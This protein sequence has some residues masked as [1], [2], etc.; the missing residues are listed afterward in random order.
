MIPG[1]LIPVRLATDATLAVFLEGSLLLGATWLLSALLRRHSPSVRHTVWTTGLVLALVVPVA[2]ALLPVRSLGVLHYPRTATVEPSADGP[3]GEGLEAA[4]PF[5]DLSG[6]ASSAAPASRVGGPGGSGGVTGFERLG[7]GLA[8]GFLA[9]WSLG[10]LVLAARLARHRIVVGRLTARGTPAQPDDAPARAVRREAIR[11]GIRR[12]VRVVY[13]SQLGV[14]VTWGVLRP[15]LLLPP[16]AV[17]WNGPLLRAV[18][19][20]ELAHVRRWDALSQQLAEV[21]RALYWTNPLVWLARRR[22]ARERESACDVEV[23]HRGMAPSE[24]AGVLVEMA[25]RG[26]DGPARLRPEFQGGLA[27]AGPSRLEARVGAILRGASRERRLAGGATLTACLGLA[28][29]AA[30][31]ATFSLMTDAPGPAE[32]EDGS[33]AGRVLTV[34]ALGLECDEVSLWRLAHTLQGDPD[35]V[36]RRAAGRALGHH[37]DPRSVQV[38]AHAAADVHQEPGVRRASV[39]ALA[40][41][42]SRWAADALA[43]LLDSADADVRREAVQAMGGMERQGRRLTDVLASA[44]LRDPDPTVR[45]AAAT[46]LG[47]T[48][49]HHAAR[50]LG[51]AV[52]DPSPAVATRAAEALERVTR[53]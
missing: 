15:V 40:R 26:S 1:D 36:V 43:D 46:A 34:R 41:R 33:L 11:M 44:L 23:V 30:P 29:V 5:P 42:D 14:P 48:A 50:W 22:A 53:R 32:G 38:L 2:G 6:A 18:T 7:A 3:P 10:V 16:D 37:D 52:R 8:T 27:L 13:T 25:R 39:H 31:L 20:H 28:V 17:H 21:A 4:S 19:V 51:R 47:S 12:R 49:C 24:Y 9:L 45:A 35:P